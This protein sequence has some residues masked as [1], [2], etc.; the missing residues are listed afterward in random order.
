MQMYIQHFLWVLKRYLLL[1][2]VGVVLCS[3]LTGVVSVMRAPKYEAVATIQVSIASGDSTND[4]FSNQ[5]IA[6]GYAL[7]MTNNDVL[8]A[9]SQKSGVSVKDLQDS[10]TAA[11]LDGTQLIGVHAITED[12]QKSAFEANAVANAFIEYEKGSE[13][14]RL[15]GILDKLR[16]EITTAQSAGDQTAVS[17]LQA[18][19][20]NV[21]IQLSMLENGLFL[22]EQALPPTTPNSTSL[23]TNLAL[24]FGL[25]L[26]LMCVF[27]ILLDWIDVS[28]KTPEDVS[29]LAQLESLGSIPLR[30]GVSTLVPPLVANDEVL[31]EAFTV[32]GANFQ[33]LYAGQRS[34]LVTG[35]R[36]RDGVTTIAS[37]LAISLAQAGLRVLLIDANLRRPAQHQVFKA[38]NARG[39]ATVLSDVYVL[40]KQR[41][42][43]PAWLS[44]WKTP[45]PNLWLLPAGTFSVSPL[46]VLRSM[47]LRKL[48]DWLV[49]DIT[50]P[51]GSSAVDLVIFDAPSLDRQ[52]DVSTLAAL[53]DGCV[54]VME[55]G[56]T[57]KDS[58]KTAQALL[59]RLS[60]PLVGVVVNRQKEK[61][62]SYFYAGQQQEEGVVVDTVPVAKYAPLRSAEEVAV[63][64]VPSPSPK[65]G[66]VL[67]SSA[68]PTPD[69]PTALLA[70]EEITPPALVA[71]SAT[72]TPEARKSSSPPSF[73]QSEE[74]APQVEAQTNPR[75]GIARASGWK[76]P[77][78]KEA[79]EDDKWGRP[80]HVTSVPEQSYQQN[81]N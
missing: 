21:Q 60:A 22:E 56:K 61:H 75:V 17:G 29:R 10:I 44:Q 8:K 7:K 72:L 1:I 46:T 35:M 27:A 68:P 25:S 76:A 33:A 4:V 40:K 2:I 78:A 69:V 6:V 9:A 26:V 54:L 36:G 45:M 73:E 20:N 18:T 50:A 11:P 12:A 51:G 66:L 67:S 24:G 77:S 23:T 64:P 52:A 42:Q 32:V 15:Q 39:L 19:Y 63:A 41:S 74:H 62:H 37:Q 16:P 79:E 34:L 14:Q 80:Q 71:N 55:A 30:K 28:I 57:S 31:D 49:Q 5:T 38:N 13:A 47:E 53:C 3:V 59:Q 70:S 48:V 58:L 65:P 43:L 81:R